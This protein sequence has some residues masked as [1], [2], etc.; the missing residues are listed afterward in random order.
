MTIQMVRKPPTNKAFNDRLKITLAGNHTLKDKTCMLQQ[1]EYYLECEQRI[2]FAGPID[3]YIALVDQYGYPLTHF[4]NGNLISDWN[5][6][7]ENP[8]HCAADHYRI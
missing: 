4:A 3:V 5:I 8:Y 6:I 2:D 1:V 7:I